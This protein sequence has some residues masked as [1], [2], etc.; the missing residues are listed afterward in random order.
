[1]TLFAAALISFALAATVVKA[2][3]RAVRPE[4]FAPQQALL[5]AVA[6]PKTNLVFLGSSRIEYG[7][8][9]DVFDE[10]MRLGG[11]DGIHSYNLG[12]SDEVLVESFANAETMFDLKSQGIKFVLFEPN[13][14]GQVF[15]LPDTLRAINYFSMG[16]VA[17][18]IEMINVPL[19]ERMG[20]TAAEYVGQIVAATLRHYSNLG[21]AWAPEDSS[22]EGRRLSRGF[23]AQEDV[24]YRVLVPDDQYRAQLQA[25]AIAPPRL[26]L[27]SDDQIDLVL[28][29]VA[30][31]K[32]HGAVPVMIKAPQISHWDYAAA[33]ADKFARRCVGKGPLYLNF[34][35]PRQYPELWDPQN[36]QDEDHLNAGGAAIFSRLI[37]ERLA[38]AIKDNS[39]S[40]PLCHR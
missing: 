40:L 27:I 2:V 21:L 9:P 28:S 1:M 39:I 33:F 38:A 22:P 7:F 23:P 35:S 25:I 10:T 18:A 12:R 36:R 26:D 24:E 34:T 16:H 19:R 3:L 31:I 30:Y 6:D 8:V 32:A 37:A 4:L 29:F 14:T 5:D 17:R 13:L 11:V 20:F 15:I